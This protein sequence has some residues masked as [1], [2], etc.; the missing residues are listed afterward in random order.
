M[1]N[2]VKDTEGLKKMVFR[3][4]GASSLRR[5]SALGVPYGRVQRGWDRE[6]SVWD[7]DSKGGK[8]SGGKES[9]GVEMKESHIRGSLA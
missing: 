3:I 2:L 6:W 8:G 5:G 4:E 9:P 7:A 1:T